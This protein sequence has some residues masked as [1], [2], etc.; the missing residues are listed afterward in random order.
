MGAFDPVGDDDER[1]DGN[2]LNAMLKFPASFAFN[3]VGRTGGEETLRDTFVLQVKEVVSSVAGDVSDCQV[4]PRGR[5][6]TRITIET[7]VESSAMINAVFDE[8][9]KL[10]MTTMRY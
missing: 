2:I 3:V 5:N 1:Q 9:D 10:D 4:I 8:L 7:T 6:F